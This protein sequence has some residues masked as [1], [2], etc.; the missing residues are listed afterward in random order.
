MYSDVIF[1]G[2]SVIILKTFKKTQTL[3]I[4]KSLKNDLNIIECFII[5]KKTKNK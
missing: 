5:T 3:K 1:Y 2:Q 4:I